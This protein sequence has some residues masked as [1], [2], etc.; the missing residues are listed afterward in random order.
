MEK[1]RWESI[2]G[3]NFHPDAENE[4]VSIL[5]NN[6]AGATNMVI[7]IGALKAANDWWWAFDNLEVNIGDIPSSVV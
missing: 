6:P 5:L 7:K 2:A 1:L 3:P 4:K